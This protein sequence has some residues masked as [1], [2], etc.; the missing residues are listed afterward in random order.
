MQFRSRSPRLVVISDLYIE[1]ISFFPN[2]TDP[3]LVVDPNAMLTCPV[4]LKGFKMVTAIDCQHPEVSRGIQ[5]EK[6]APRRLLDC[7]KADYRLIVEDGF[8]VRIPERANRHY[9]DNMTHHVKY[10][11][12]Y[13]IR[14]IPARDFRRKVRA[15]LG[16]HASMNGAKHGR[17]WRSCDG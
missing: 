14:K 13:S 3:P 7:L 4:F 8:G 17:K 16:Y 12:S 9:D 10:Q 6:F 5:H 2:E 1:R 11:T 15:W